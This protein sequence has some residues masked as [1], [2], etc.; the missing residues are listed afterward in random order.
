MKRAW[1]SLLCM[2]LLCGCSAKAEESAETA[3]QYTFEVAEEGIRVCRDGAFV[4]LLEA[5]TA[6]LLGFDEPEAHLWQEDYDF[7]QYPD[8]FV[9]ELLG[10]PNVPGRYF[11]FD[12]EKELFTEWEALNE[13]GYSAAVNDTDRT[14]T[15]SLSGSA[16]DHRSTVCEWQDGALVQVRGEVQYAKGSEVYIDS[17]AYADG[18]EVLLTRERV[19]ISENGDWLGTEEVAIE[20]K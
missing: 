4:Q 6:E 18:Q 17:F 14:L 20:E 10:R 7:D 5:D 16:V 8:L 15:F 19:L 3:A 13:F 11:R 12:A 2:A 9:P 1:I